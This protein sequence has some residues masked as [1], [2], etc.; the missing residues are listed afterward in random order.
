MII[1]P[2]YLISSHVAYRDAL[3]RLLSTMT[4]I[5]ARRKLVYIGGAAGR[6]AVNVNGHPC[7]E[8]PHNSFD[9]TALIEWV[10]RG[11]SHSHI[12]LLHDTMEFGP[13]SDDLIRKADPEMDAT[14][15]YPGGQTNLVCYRGDYAR[16]QRFYIPS[17]R[18][19]SKLKAIEQEGRLWKMTEK[20]AIYPNSKIVTTDAGRP[21]NGAKRISEMYE[22]VNI[23]KLKANYGQTM[24]P[25]HFELRM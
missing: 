9:Y 24:T 8:V 18:D 7:T 11:C 4:H 15:A 17:L 14:A 3:A 2:V 23:R 12:F 19:C 6:R 5:E 1:Q 10:E 25:E 13:T 21:Y 22:A 20:R 16:A